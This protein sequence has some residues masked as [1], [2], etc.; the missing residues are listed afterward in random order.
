MPVA[1][2]LMPKVSLRSMSGPTAGV[3]GPLV[4]GLFAFGVMFC[5]TSRLLGGGV[6]ASIIRERPKRTCP[7]SEA[8]CPRV[9]IATWV[10]DVL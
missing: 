1:A 6:G 7:P 4:F 10:G 8:A 2:P 9:I 5:P 3:W